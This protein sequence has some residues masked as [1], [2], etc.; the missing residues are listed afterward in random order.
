MKAILCKSF[1]PPESLVVEETSDPRLTDDGVLIQVHAAGVNFPDTLIIENKYQ[2]KPPLPFTPGS[3]VSGVVLEVGKKVTRFKP[4]DAVMGFTGWGAFA[5]KIVVSENTCFPKPEALSFEEAS[6]FSMIY[7]TSYYALKQRGQLK[8]GETLL[9]LGA[10]GGVGLAAVELGKLMGA[11]VIAAGGNDEKLAITQ[12]YGA[13]HVVN[14][15]QENW[16]D[17]V[18][19]LTGGK[20]ADVIYDP[21]GGDAFDQAMRCI[22]WNG[23]LLVIGF[24]SG[25]IPELPA[26]LA[27]LKSA[28]IVGVFWGASLSKEAEANKENFQELFQ[29]ANAGKIKPHVC[30]SLPMEQVA[31]AL[32]LMLDRK[33]VGKVVLKMV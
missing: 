23:R 14:Y 2:F 9:V 24:A 22:N 16:K 11:T 19:Q 31:E 33:A 18:K 8:P 25:R 1:G 4:G 10:A 5:E 32:N 21:V 26:N 13:D 30:A 27:L 12:Q 28:N 29:F 20:G 7:G 17:Q 15:N 6:G 3:E